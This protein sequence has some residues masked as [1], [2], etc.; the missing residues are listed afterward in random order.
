MEAAFLQPLSLED[1]LRLFHSWG[2]EEG[3]IQE[4]MTKK[5]LP[6]YFVAWLEN[7]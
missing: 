4:D 5:M 7:P 6:G 2:Q 3:S 1:D